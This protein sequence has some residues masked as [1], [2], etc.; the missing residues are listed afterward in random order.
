MRTSNHE[1]H[2]SWEGRSATALPDS[3]WKPVEKG[4]FRF[5]A[6]YFIIQIVPLAPSFWRDLFTANWQY[7]LYQPLFKLAR[8]MPN[9]VGG[10]GSFLNWVIAAAL[11]GLGTFTW[12][13][14]EKRRD[15]SGKPVLNYD[16]L[17]AWV[18]VLVRYRLAAG[19]L[20]F[21]L[22]KLF[23]I[24]APEPSLSH[25]NT[26]YG[27]L[28]EWKIFALTLGVVPSYQAFLGLIETLAGLLLLTRRSATI[29]AFITVFF[30]GN[31]FISNVAYGGGEFVYSLFLISLAL[32]LL[33]YDGLRLYNLLVLGKPTA[34]N[35]YRLT[36]A[37][38]WQQSARLAGKVVAA[39]LILSYGLSAYEAL[40][41]GGHQYPSAAKKASL[42]DAAGLYTV[43]EF[44]LN[45][46]SRPPSPQDSLRWQ[47]VV[48]EKWNTISIRRPVPATLAKLNQEDVIGP[49]SARHFEW[50]G[51]IGRHY[52]HYEPVAEQ[53]ASAARTLQ[54]RNPQH[55]EDTFQLR[56][57]R[58]NPGTLVLAGINAK[59]DSVYA[60]LERVDKKY[61]LFEAAK[62]GRRKGLTL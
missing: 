42:S 43:Q 7:G 13:I 45:G 60:V 16:Q 40:R 51:Q 28:T 58:P 59:N 31:V 39:L 3:G 29:G 35:R 14:W 34:P 57:E 9:F 24:Q 33:A 18:R 6:L 46:Q 32:Y 2:P 11:A 5:V 22:I 36:F 8:Y 30:T 44:R 25:L 53:A 21:G 62:S 41:K 55:P 4:L 38:G 26:P 48:V 54:L 17:N 19:L 12:S 49:D 50:S 23:P 52:Y 37:Q 47:N 27:E 1:P 20:A 61:L 56:Y 10:T 15:E